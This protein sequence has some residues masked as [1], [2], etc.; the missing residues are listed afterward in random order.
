MEPCMQR[1]SLAGGAPAAVVAAVIRRATAA[2]GKLAREPLVHFLAVGLALFALGQHY[3]RDADLHHI[4]VT[5]GHRAQ[6]A[7]RYAS[8]FGRPPGATTLASLVDADLDDEMLYRR[9]LELGLDRDDEIIRRRIVQKMRFLLQDLAAPAEP[10]EAQ[11][12][13]YYAAHL[14]RYD[15]PARVT[16]SH[17]YFSDRSGEAEAQARAALALDELAHDGRAQPRDIG[18]A[19]PDLYHFAGYDAAQVQRLFGATPFSAALFSAPLGR[20]AGPYASAYGWHLIRVEERQAAAERPLSAVRERVR[21]DY[22]L[23]AQASANRAALE[24][25]A[26]TFTVERR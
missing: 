12:Q 11:L 15:A 21:S 22:L 18:D 19:F 26:R 6:L 23:D 1:A 4:V 14:E 10:S 3:R 20:W 5:P 16:F 24:K 13:A 8:Q 17:I 7:A 2:A 9:G 25:L